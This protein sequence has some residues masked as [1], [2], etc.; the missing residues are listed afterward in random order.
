MINRIKTLKLIS[1]IAQLVRASDSYFGG[2]RFESSLNYLITTFL[3][4][5]YVHKN[6][7]W[8]SFK[9]T[10]LNSNVVNISYLQLW[11]NNKYTIQKNKINKKYFFFKNTYT[12]NYPFNLYVTHLNF[13]YKPLI[14]SLNMWSTSLLLLIPLIFFNN[15]QLHQIT[16]KLI[17]NSLFFNK[18][19]IVKSMSKI[20]KKYN[21][22]LFVY[23]KY[24]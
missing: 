19:F 14:K 4:K 22:N 5:K 20:N 12:N 11:K 2:S 8:L 24:L 9:S 10:C 3:N 17:I 15:L 13:F 23:H 6:L 7:L 18:F 21:S 1:L 16:L